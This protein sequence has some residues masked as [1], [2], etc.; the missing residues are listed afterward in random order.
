M[1]K[2][3]HLPTSVGG[4]AWGLAQGE[5]RLG[6][7][8]Q[9]LYVQDNWLHYPVDKVMTLS[10][11][12]IMRVAKG[13]EAY[14][15]YARKV[16]V[17]H[18][19][20][21]SSL[22]DIQKLNLDL[23]DLRWYRRQKL[24][25]TYNGCDAR[26]KFVRIQQTKI[27]AC[28]HQ[29]CQN[30]IC[31]SGELDARKARRISLFDAAGAQIFAVN[32]DLLRFLPDSAI[33]LPYTIA[34]WDMLSP[35]PLLGDKPLTV[36]HAPTDR[37]CKGTDTVMRVL[38]ILQ[39]EYG[40]AIQVVYVEN[41]THGDALKL[42]RQADII[43]DQLRIGWYGGLAV[44]C[45]RL[46]KPVVVYLNHDD[47]NLIPADMAG[48]CKEAFIEANEA[49]LEVVLRQYIENRSLLRVKREAALAFVNRWHD[50]LAVATITKEAYERKL[51]FRD[52]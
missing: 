8:S 14:F 46:G 50:P 49:N 9:V 19:N 44:E 25:V 36:L 12:R 13:I 37:V 26:Q 30:G 18:F 42:Y 34:D 6:L 29:G 33:F 40:D 3:L 22:V 43:I 28:A 45:M 48:D 11:S 24:F 47:L 41:V 2:V 52:R 23:L 27:S 38:N 4:N 16:D 32:P 35:V 15:R 21:G 17:L 10:H 51:D 1:I 7:D 31:D 20:F 5:R 39:Q